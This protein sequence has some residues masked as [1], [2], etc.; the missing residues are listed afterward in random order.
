MVL[1]LRTW[2]FQG[3]WGLVHR[4]I[5]IVWVLGTFKVNGSISELLG[6]LFLLHISPSHKLAVL[7]SWRTHNFNLIILLLLLGDICQLFLDHLFTLHLKEIMLPL[8]VHPVD[9]SLR[10]HI[11]R[12]G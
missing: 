9:H 7:N 10:M 1:K 5:L 4:G 6:D 3:H 11:H 12:L 8:P 2:G